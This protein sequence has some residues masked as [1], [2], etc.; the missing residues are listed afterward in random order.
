MTSLQRMET[1]VIYFYAQEKQSVDV[2]VDFPQGMITEWYPQTAQIGP[3]ATPAPA[4]VAT[5]DKVLHKAGASPEFTLTSL[6]DHRAS[7]SSRARWLN[8]QVMPPKESEKLKASLLRDESGSHYFSARDTDASL[9]QIDSLA[10]SGKI[11]L[12]SRRG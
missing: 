8:V 7:R 6:V 1:P 9:L 2:S 3:A 11:Y 5:A 4:G 12:L 10:R